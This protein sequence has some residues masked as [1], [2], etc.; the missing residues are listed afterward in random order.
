[1]IIPEAILKSLEEMDKLSNFIEVCDH[2]IK[3]KYYD[4]AGKTP[5][6]TISAQL[7]DFIRKCDTRVKRIKGEAGIYYYYL[8]KNEQ[9]IEF[10]NLNNITE[11]ASAKDNSLVTLKKAN[12][13]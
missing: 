12:K 6:S 11:K 9:K 7:G 13:T 2:I 8:T 5:A 4:F 10:E 1:M 3:K